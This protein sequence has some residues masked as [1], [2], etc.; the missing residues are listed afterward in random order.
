MNVLFGHHGLRGDVAINIPAASYLHKEFGWSVDIALNK[1]FK[2]MIPLFMNHPE[3]NSVFITD[4]YDHF[5]SAGDALQIRDRH[6]DKVFNPMQPHRDE[7]WFENLHQTSAVLVDYLCILMP[8]EYEQISLVKWFDPDPY[9][10]IVAISPFAGF[11]HNPNNNKRLTEEKAQQI[12]DYILGKGFAVYQMSGP[13]EP[14]LKNTI[15]PGLS[16]FDSIKKMLSCKFLIHTDTGAGWI[17]SAYKFPQ[18]GLYGTEYHGKKN[19][20][21]IQP[22]NPNSIYLDAPT[23]GE[24]PIESIF[25]KIDLLLQ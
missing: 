11:E 1:R 19:I 9:L 18:L 13:G 15:F 12:V 2:D 5:P 3:I 17:A 25:D 6:Y 7:R 16:Y 20:H 8:K 14:K 24:I 10:P 21:N 23:V 22:V 4:S